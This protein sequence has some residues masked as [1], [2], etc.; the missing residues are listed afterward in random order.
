MDKAYI[1]DIN[2]VNGYWAVLDSNGKEIFTST[3]EWEVQDKL[4]EI[5]SDTE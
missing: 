5:I 2:G 4:D 3:D 1:S